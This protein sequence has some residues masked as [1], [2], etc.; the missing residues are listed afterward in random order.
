ME[1][2]E[3]G[4]DERETDVPHIFYAVIQYWMIALLTKERMKVE[5]K[6]KSE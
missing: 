6:R 1:R 4:R 5:V 2:G 3:K